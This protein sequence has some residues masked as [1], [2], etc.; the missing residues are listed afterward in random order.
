MKVVGSEIFIRR[1]KT[2][3]CNT[4]GDYQLVNIPRLSP[5]VLLLVFARGESER[6]RE[7]ERRQGGNPPTRAEIGGVAC[8]RA[9]WDVEPASLLVLPSASGER[10]AKSG[11]ASLRWSPARGDRN[12]PAVQQ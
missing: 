12:E 8:P 1:E 5:I 11:S 10:K 7:Q 3:G 4:W 9:G 2:G 6:E